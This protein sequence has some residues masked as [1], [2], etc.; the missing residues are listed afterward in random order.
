MGYIY[1][2]INKLNGRSYIGQTVQL[3]RR[4][5]GH[6]RSSNSGDTVIGKAIKKYGLDSFEFI[7]LEEAESQEEL[8]R[9]ECYYISLYNTNLSKGGSGYNLTDGG[10]AG[11]KGFKMSDE[12]RQ[13]ISQKKHS[14]YEHSPE[15][16]E[17]IS[18]SVKKLWEDEEYIKKNTVQCPVDI[19]SLV[20]E[21]EGLSWNDIASKFNVSAT[22]VKKWF[23]NFGLKK[24]KKKEERKPWTQEEEQLLL[25]LRKSGHLIREISQQLGRSEASILKRSQKILDLN[26]IKRPR[27]FRKSIK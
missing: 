17:K 6:I 22:T 12:T 18:S 16:I 8:D 7:V 20:R 14:L 10:Y 24:E 9:L 27:Y 15:V 4:W 11:V 1:R 3:R 25:D 19:D 26:N 13:I 23:K 5:L 21:S 2:I